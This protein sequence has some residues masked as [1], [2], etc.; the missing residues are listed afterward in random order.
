MNVAMLMVR[1]K[2]KSFRGA[3]AAWS[4]FLVIGD[5]AAG[6]PEKL[7]HFREQGEVWSAGA[8][9]ASPALARIGRCPEGLQNALSRSPLNPFLF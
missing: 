1:G 5:L 4:R 7:L 9:V 8:S 6:D 3:T 2:E